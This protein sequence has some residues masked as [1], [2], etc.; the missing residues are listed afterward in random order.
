[1]GRP[2]AVFINKKK[3]ESPVFFGTLGPRQL[4]AEIMTG[5]EENISSRLALGV[6]GLLWRKAEK[7]TTAD[8]GFLLSTASGG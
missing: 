1:M 6:R 3:K 4:A 7:A 8:P 2:S 5:A